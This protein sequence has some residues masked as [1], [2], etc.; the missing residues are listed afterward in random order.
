MSGLFTHRLGVLSSGGEA[1]FSAV[2]L[3]MGFEGPNGSTTFVD[4]S[5]YAKTATTVANAQISTTTPKYGSSCYLSDGSGDEVTFVD[6]ADWDFGTGPFTIEAFTR[7]TNFAGNYRPIVSQWDSSDASKAWTFINNDVTGRVQFRARIG[8]VDQILTGAT[9]PTV[10]TWIHCAVD[11][12]ASGVLRV[13]LDGVMDG[14]DTTNF[15]AGIQSSG[16]ILRVGASVIGA[17]NRH[18]IGRM[19]ELRITKG[20]ARYGSDAGFT[21]PAEAFP[22]S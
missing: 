12:D 22:R 20:Y 1:P 6:S 15:N 8:G 7:N 17:T 18:M 10:N 4:E 16:N 21:P 19:D 5:S 9:S 3:L 2:V 13:Y 14:K 11:R